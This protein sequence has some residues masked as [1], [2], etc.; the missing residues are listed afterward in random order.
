MIRLDILSPFFF[1]FVE[2]L[3][4]GSQAVGAVNYTLCYAQI[5]GISRREYVAC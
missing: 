1:L 4:G 5:E 3:E 2:I